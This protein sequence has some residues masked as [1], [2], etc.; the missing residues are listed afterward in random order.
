[1]PWALGADGHT[2]VTEMDRAMVSI[3][4]CKNDLTGCVTHWQAVCGPVM[5]S[6]FDACHYDVLW[7]YT[8]TR[9]VLYQ[10]YMMTRNWAR[11][12]EMQESQRPDAWGQY[13][14]TWTAMKHGRTGGMMP[15]VE[16]FLHIELWI[17]EEPGLMPLVKYFLHIKLWIAGEPGL[18]PL[19]KYVLVIELWIM[20]ESETRYLWQHLYRLSHEMLEGRS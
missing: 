17:A 11:F 14:L 16:Y 18:M 3:Y 6:I 10:L 2:G 15:L 13:F 19:V 12:H 9:T 4:T 1:M 20:G 8:W 5:Q 7:S